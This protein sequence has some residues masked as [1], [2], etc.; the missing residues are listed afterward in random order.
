MDAGS[1]ER[2]LLKQ[3]QKPTDRNVRAL[4][5]ALAR[6][7]KLPG[8][9]VRQRVLPWG[10]ITSYDGGRGGG[11]GDAPVFRPVVSILA[12]RAEIGWSGP[13]AL[14]GGVV[15]TISDKEIMEVDPAT[16]QRPVLKVPLAEFADAEEIGIFF[17][18]TADPADDYR[19]R[20]VE[21]VALPRLP[22]PAP[23]LAHTLALFLRRRAG[24]LSYDESDDRELFCGQ[25]FLAVNR[26]Q[27]G[28]FTPLFWARHG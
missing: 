24:R 15:P 10:T 3:A 6:S 25:G 26:R 21:P 17:R 8:L 23:H 11:G 12:D 27:N 14:I 7:Q 9:G 2:L 22:A 20:T 5:A 28:V 16:G 4:D 18:V 13:R 19:A 1:I